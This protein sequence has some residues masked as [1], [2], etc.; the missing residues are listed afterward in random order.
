MPVVTHGRPPLVWHVSQFFSTVLRGPAK[1]RSA[2]NINKRRKR[3]QR[4][5]SLTILTS[6]TKK[7]KLSSVEMPMCTIWRHMGAG[8]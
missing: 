2:N 4:Q 8:G 5:L 6:H 3:A 7:H 1:G